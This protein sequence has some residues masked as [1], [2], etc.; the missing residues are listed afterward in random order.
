VGGFSPDAVLIVC[1]RA[2]EKI[3]EH[4]ESYR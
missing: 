1:R 3:R 2:A 4:F